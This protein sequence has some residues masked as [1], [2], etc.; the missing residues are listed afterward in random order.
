MRL[1]TIKNLIAEMRRLNDRQRKKLSFGINIIK[2][3]VSILLISYVISQV[4]WFKSKP[5]LLS[6]NPWF[7]LSTF[8]VF[9]LQFP[10]SAYKWQQSLQVH[11][12]YYKFHFLLKVMCIA[13][14]FN[15][16][17]PTTI[18]GDGYRILK[19]LPYSGSKSRAVSSIMVERLIGLSA[20]LLLGYF[21]SLYSLWTSPIIL[22]EMYSL[23]ASVLLILALIAVLIFRNTNVSGFFSS[24]LLSHGKFIFIKENLNY[25]IN[26]KRQIF[27]VIFVSFFFHI[28]AFLG[29]YFLY[30][31]FGVNIEYSACALIAAIG[32]VISMLPISINGIGVVESAYIFVA[33]N[34]SISLEHAT[35]FAFS[36]RLMSIPFSLICGVIYMLDFKKT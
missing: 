10:I 28:V 35:I 24:K 8:V 32:G 1:S 31:G 36:Y 4:D 9:I 5:I 21:F 29:M 16:F 23:I 22:T 6:I 19:T 13:F 15:N 2:A 33:T 7:A 30:K 26:S 14:F 12:L 27:I 18:G 17:L 25:I 11:H 20:L 34:F 3:V